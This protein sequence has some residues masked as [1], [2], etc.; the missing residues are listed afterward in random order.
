MHAGGDEVHVTTADPDV[1]GDPPAPVTGDPPAH[2]HR[3]ILHVDLDQFQVSVE[4]QRAPE[5][6]GV[7]VIVGGTGDPQAPRTVV[8]CASYEARDVGV[9]AGMPL[10]AAHRKLP[11]AVYLPTDH[12][13]YD[14]ASEQVMSVLRGLG[15]PVEVWGWDEAYLG[16]DVDDPHALAATVIKRIRDETGLTCAVGISDNKQ[17]AKMATNFAKAQAPGTDRVDI[18]TAQTWMDRM[19]HRPCRELWSVGPK[20]AQ[21]LTALG[22]DTV[23]DLAATPRD[24]L[25]AT[26]GPHQGTWLNVLARGGGDPTI[27]A[28][29]YVARSHSKVQTFP[30]DVTDVD[31]LHRRAEE[32]TSD[33]LALVLAE[34]RV[35][36][37]VAVTVRTATFF[38]RTKS[39]KLPTTTTHLADIEPSVHTLLDRFELDRPVRLLGVRLELVVD[40]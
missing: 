16:A 9:R 4:R 11:D 6:V 31:E 14:V 17:R 29:P 32:L 5:L 39:R 19:G 15:H 28:E 8:T 34:G 10:R 3:W 20:T 30:V 40:D 33:V 38:T 2:R 27:T 36:T 12:A 23:A 13:A 7:P 21:K 37:R 26:F 18:L 1:S 24:D 22:I 25:I 35:V